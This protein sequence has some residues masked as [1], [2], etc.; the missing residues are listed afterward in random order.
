[1]KKTLLSLVAIA[2]LSIGAQAQIEIYVEGDATNTNYA[3]G[4]VYTV[5]ANGET[6]QV[7]EIHVEN[8]TGS[9]QSWV[10]NRRRIDDPASWT[11][12][13]CWGHE[14]DNFGGT[15]IDAQSMDM[16]LYLM[17][18]TASTIVDVSDGEY[19]F[20]ASH[21]TP[22]YNDPTTVTYRY[23]VGDAGN[24][25]IDS[26]DLVMVMTPLSIEEKAPELTIGVKPNPA[27]DY[28]VVSAGG[29]ETATVRII[30]VLGNVIMKST[31]SGSKNVDVSE[32][33]NGIYFVTVEANGT[34]V[35]RKVFVRH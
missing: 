25:F 6:D 18:M 27:T 15:C 20:I 7:H 23:Y 11:D 34:K 13:L 33:R 16:E 31:V 2:G 10:I 26:M 12:F 5:Y 4:G 28:I 29:V 9:N 17:P 32:Y 3:G 8:H 21:I 1:M 35:S 22:S 14:S 24:N 30:D 19:G